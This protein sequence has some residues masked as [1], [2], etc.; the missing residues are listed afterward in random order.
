MQ[1]SV[2]LPPIDLSPAEQ[3]MMS[4][5][6]NGMALPFTPGAIVKFPVAACDSRLSPQH[7]G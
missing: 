3:V 1:P 6:P 4:R 7:P 2:W 5:C